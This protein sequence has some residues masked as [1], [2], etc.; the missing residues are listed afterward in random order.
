MNRIVLHIGTHKTGTTSF[1]RWFR[2]NADAIDAVCGATLY[3]GRARDARELGAICIDE[4]RDTP[5]LR[6]RVERDNHEFPGTLTLPGTQARE[7]MI[8]EVHENIRNQ[9]QKTRD[10]FVVSSESLS[11][12][13][14]K[15]EIDRLAAMFPAG[16]TT[17][18]V[19]LRRPEDFLRSWSKH[20][21]RDFFEVSDDPT[22]FAYV[23]PDSWLVD[24]DDLLSAYTN[25]YGKES[26]VVIDYDTAMAEHGSTIPKIAEVFCSNPTALPSWNSYLFNTGEKSPRKPIRGIS[27]PRHYRRY[28]IWLVGQWG[29]NFGHAFSKHVLRRGRNT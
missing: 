20:L 4:G 19:C 10:T 14:S 16:E 17:V 28:Y 12:L 26:I 5:G 6:R 25:V 24:Y 11:L 3:E 21:D 15:S 27:K 22:S 8:T 2:D 18:V 23:K 7:Q 1:Q 9:I 13:R 29:R